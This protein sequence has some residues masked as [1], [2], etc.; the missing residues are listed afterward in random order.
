MNRHGMARHGKSLLISTSKV[1]YA[2]EIGDSASKPNKAKENTM[3]TISITQMRKM[4]VK[5]LV[6]LISRHEVQITKYGR[7]QAIMVPVGP[8]F[9]ASRLRDFERQWKKWDQKERI[10]MP[11]N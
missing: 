1:L 7:P 2:G 8:Y 5:K 3:K 6:R 10:V 9:S 4:P 11:L